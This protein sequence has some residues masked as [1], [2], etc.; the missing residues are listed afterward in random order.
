MS[1][2]LLDRIWDHYPEGGGELLTALALAEHADPDGSS[3]YPGIE[4][5]VRMTR[6]SRRTV[7]THIQHMLET[8]WL[9]VV[10]QGGGR[11]RLTEYRIPIERISAQARNTMQKLHSL[12]AISDEKLDR[13]H[14]ETV[15][16]PCR[17]HAKRAS[18]STGTS[19]STSTKKQP[20][21]RYG[22]TQGLS[23]AETE[24]TAAAA[25]LIFPEKLS[26]ADCSVA[27]TLLK[28]KPNAQLVLDELAGKMK[29]E[30]VR[31]PLA[32][33]K[34][35]VSM[36][37]R[38]EFVPSHA[39]QIEAERELAQTQREVASARAGGRHG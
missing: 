34:S 17:N 16:K 19:T 18:G 1:S 11:G 36:H 12:D 5:I 14:A 2:K 35:F 33:L 6:Q 21:L 38:N 7:H 8:G 22:G 4:T 23:T 13:N 26:S 29:V 15:Q 3:I 39:H 30:H 31:N 9:L 10:E 28:G 20:Q 24:N 25:F 32:L 27:A 37:L